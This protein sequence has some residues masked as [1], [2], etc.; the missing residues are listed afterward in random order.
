MG[1]KK[2]R[3]T[4]R[5]FLRLAGISAGASLASERSALRRP[6]KGEFEDAAG[7]PARPWWV[8]TVDKP[9]TDIDWDRM[10]RYNER[11]GTVRGPGFARYVGEE[12]A[13]R[14]DRVA[15]QL[16]RQRILDHVPGYTLKDR[17]LESAQRFDARTAGS[18]LGPQLA[19]SP[20][21]RNVPPWSGSPE[22]AAR[23]L[24]V[25]MRHFGAAHVGFVELDERTRKLIY[26]VDP[27]GKELSF[28]DV[29]EAYETEQERVIPFE[30]KWVIVYTVRQ[31]T[32][33][34]KRA[35]AATAEQNSSLNYGRAR[36]IQN[37]TQEFLRALGYQCLGESSVNALGIAPAF[38]V[39]A[40]LGE[41]SRM[42]RLITPE[43]GPMVR[44]SKMI[45][46]LP[47]ATDKP[48]DA[49]IVEFCSVC[50]KCAEAC[51]PGA[52]S[53]DDDP[54]W[55]IKG[56]WNNPGHQAWFEDSVKCYTYW[57]EGP[58]TGCGIC[59][60]VCPFSKEDQAWIHEWVKSGVS[61]LPILDGFLRSMDDAFGYGSQKDPEAWWELDL[62]EYGID[63]SRTPGSG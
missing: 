16:E 48:I 51:P 39:L 55:E 3:L 31:S 49:G 1:T 6:S 23:I 14:L 26:A 62:P 42:N 37:Q 7:R 61:S 40:G 50:K 25:A 63:T 44:V 9:T 5:D 58:G 33:T 19:P 22:E 35:P 47:L 13:E 36:H 10:Q 24:R 15:D 52:I 20:A 57:K 59:F 32:E 30:A 56:G 21:E 34:L 8:R 54:S 45:T 17:A 12:E 53:F 41:M 46:D 4:R 27:D 18:F 38:A 29:P 43:F 11:R 2:R 28:E 60:A